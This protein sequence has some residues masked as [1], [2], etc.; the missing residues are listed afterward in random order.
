[1]KIKIKKMIKK[2]FNKVIH[3]KLKKIVIFILWI[4]VQKILKIIH[5]LYPKILIKNIQ[6][7][8]IFLSKEKSLKN[9]KL[10]NKSLPRKTKT[11]I[12]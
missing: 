7:I 11:I 4:A 9:N 12:T 10:K 2:I 8:L 3:Y 1:M 5:L 6:I